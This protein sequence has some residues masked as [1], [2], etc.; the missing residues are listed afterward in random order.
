M[1]TNKQSQSTSVP[2]WTID[3]FTSTPLGDNP[4]AVCMLE[5]QRSS[6][7]MQR[8]AG[9]MNLSETAYIRPLEDGIYGD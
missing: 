8:V 3:A 7:W 1:T 9:A 2:I 6:D 5:E 4:A